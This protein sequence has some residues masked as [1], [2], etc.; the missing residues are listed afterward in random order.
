MPWVG[1]PGTHHRY[2]VRTSYRKGHTVQHYYG[3]GEA[4]QLMATF[5]AASRQRR[6]AQR[7]RLQEK[8]QH[9]QDAFE[10]LYT[11]EICCREFRTRYLTMAGFHQHKRTWRRKRGHAVEVE[12]TETLIQ[13]AQLGDRAA[14][15]QL[16]HAPHQDAAALVRLKQHAGDLTARAIELQS[17]LAFPDNLIAQE[18]IQDAAQRMAQRLLSEHPTQVERVLIEQLVCCWVG[19]SIGGMMATAT[20]Q[21]GPDKPLAREWEKRYDRALVRLRRTT[22]AL[23]RTRRLVHGHTR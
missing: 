17:Q 14:L 16:Q 1:R 22:E 6:Q 12:T 11:L 10:P 8:R 13:Q 7:A 15:A 18:A 19:V 20:A 21:D 23:G 3:R 4:A 5:D 9:L 2:Y